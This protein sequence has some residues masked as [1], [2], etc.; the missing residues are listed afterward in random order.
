MAE[1][2]AHGRAYI[3]AGRLAGLDV[4]VDAPIP[5]AAVQLFHQREQRGGLAGLA[6]GVQDEVLALFD[7]QQDG[8]QIEP[9]QRR[10]EIVN[11][12]IDRPCRVEEAHAGSVAPLPSLVC[13]TKR[14]G[15]RVARAAK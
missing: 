4:H 1:Y 6:R 2:G 11:L 14:P 5:P 8:G 12:G 10:D 9:R 7:K 15:R 13:P 3:L